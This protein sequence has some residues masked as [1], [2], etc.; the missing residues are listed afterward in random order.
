LEKALCPPSLDE[1]I[2]EV[3]LDTGE[4]DFMFNGREWL[5]CPHAAE[6]FERSDLPITF[7]TGMSL[8]MLDGPAGQA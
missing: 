2:V 3:A 4:G 5:P 8:A 1:Q 6:L 7:Y